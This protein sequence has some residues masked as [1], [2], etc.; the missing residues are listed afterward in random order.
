[1]IPWQTL[2]FT[3][4][5]AVS[6]GLALMGGLVSFR[7][8][9]GDRRPAGQF[10][11]YQQFFIYAFLLYGI[12][13]N[14][15][16]QKLLEGWG[17][18]E[19]IR[20][21]VM[22]AQPLLG[23]PFLL[24]AWYMLIRLFREVTGGKWR[25]GATLAYLLL[26]AAIVP[27]A[28]LLAGKTGLPSGETNLLPGKATPT[29]PTASFFPVYTLIAASNGVLHLAL[30]VAVALNYKRV[31]RN[32]CP[33]SRFFLPGFFITMAVA[34]VLTLMAP[35]H[36]YIY[37]L[38][39]ILMAFL[40]NLLLPLCMGGLRINRIEGAPASLGQGAPDHP[41]QTGTAEDD[42][43]ES[44]NHANAFEAFCQKYEI[45]RREAEVIREIRSGKS[46]REIADTLFITLQ[47][48]KDHIHRIFIKTGVTNRVQLINLSGRLT[49]QRIQ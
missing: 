38:L 6:A 25:K 44:D 39:A 18:E 33:E 29:F 9:A 46:N 12:W 11:V 24:A 49:Q 35:G 48:V 37:A 34:T 5:F 40:A 28:I 15:A 21:R 41:R 2:L 32:E 20:N 47:T 42:H 13:G 36:H 31:I 4:T 45:S 23:L 19:A 30:L 1:M 3:L 17:V 43:Q 27:L 7:Y 26:C 14:L 16:M 10:L 22:T 8:A